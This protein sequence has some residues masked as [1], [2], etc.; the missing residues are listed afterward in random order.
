MESMS[1]NPG[2]FLSDV[3][4]ELKRVSWPTKKQLVRYTLTVIATV[5]FV[6]IFFAVVDLGITALLDL[7]LG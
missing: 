7:I 3:T 6:A 1:K 4:T 5:A 2:K